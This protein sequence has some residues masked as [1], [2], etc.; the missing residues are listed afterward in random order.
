[1][2]RASTHQCVALA[3]M[4]VHVV[5]AYVYTYADRS[6]Y[7]FGGKYIG[8]QSKRAL[9]VTMTDTY[10]LVLRMYAYIFVC[11]YIYVYIYTHIY[12]YT[13]VIQAHTYQS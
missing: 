3:G 1:M 13:C 7:V 8:M 6:A 5:C 12:M 4:Y 11:V 10:V 2:H 9:C